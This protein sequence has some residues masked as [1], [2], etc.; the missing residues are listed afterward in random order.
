MAMLF[1]THQAE[2]E[3]R[4]H[5]SLKEALVKAIG[6]G[7]GMDLNRAEFTIHPPRASEEATTASVSIDG[8]VKDKWR[9]YTQA[10]G[11]PVDSHDAQPSRGS[12]HWITVGR[13]PPED[14]IDAVGEFT[15][16]WRQ[17]EFSAEEWEAERDA[18]HPP[19][20]AVTLGDLVPE[21]HKATFEDAGGECYV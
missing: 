11:A 4:R 10:F 18:P 2:N 12:R 20:V 17:R 19:F 15:S 14:V 16:T 21:R 3:F 6:I 1:V 8:G 5:W 7:L 9:F 13:G